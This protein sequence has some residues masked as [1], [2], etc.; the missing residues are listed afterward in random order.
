VASER[1]P[2]GRSF[3]EEERLR[4]SSMNILPHQRAQL[5][6]ISRYASLESVAL[7]APLR[8]CVEISVGRSQALSALP[9][10]DG[11]DPGRGAVDVDLVADAVTQQPLRQFGPVGEDALADVSV[12]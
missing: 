8:L 3:I 5:A 11:G 12:P 7:F 10:L 6:V 9:G 4:S 2:G 1:P